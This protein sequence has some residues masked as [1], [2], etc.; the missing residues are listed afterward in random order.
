MT[1]DPWRMTLLEAANKIETG[2]WCQGTIR[3]DGCHCI[4]GALI[5]VAKSEFGK[6]LDSLRTTIASD[7]IIIWND[8]PGRTKEEVITALR[9][10]A[11]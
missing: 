8:T 5:A 1:I 3:R 10:A 6:A 7:K 2:G 4:M 11:E 9:R